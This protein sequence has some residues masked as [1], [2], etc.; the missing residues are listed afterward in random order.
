MLLADKK[1]KAR[2]LK[3]YQISESELLSNAKIFLDKLFNSNQNKELYELKK[4][5]KDLKKNLARNN[6][7]SLRNY[8]TRIKKE[9]WKLNDFII[10]IQQEYVTKSIA[11]GM[12]KKNALKRAGFYTYHKSNKYYIGDPE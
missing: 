3:L 10:F 1:D 7:D 9:G 12:P 2:T 8:Q 4:I 5:F 11:D 6:G